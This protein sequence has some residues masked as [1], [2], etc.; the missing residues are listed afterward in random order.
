MKKLL[1]VLLLIVT[2]NS[3]S[4]NFYVSGGAGLSDKEESY[5]A[6]AGVYTNKTWYGVG[7]DYTPEF[8]EHFVSLKFYYQIVKDKNLSLYSYNAFKFRTNDRNLFFEPGAAFVYDFGKWAPQFTA[9]VPSTFNDGKLRATLFYGIGINFW[10]P[11][12][13]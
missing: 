11:N 1:T 8:K 5:S 10:I 3:F 2:V 9:T 12:K 4:Q 13:T 6:E 7:Y